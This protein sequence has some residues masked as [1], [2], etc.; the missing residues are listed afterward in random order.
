MKVLSTLLAAA[1]SLAP[2]AP[3]A[4]EPV[5]PLAGLDV[6][7]MIVPSEDD[8][9]AG[10]LVSGHVGLGHRWY[11][12]LVRT[13]Y[14]TDRVDDP[15]DPVSVRYHD[16]LVT[17]SVRAQRGRAWVDLGYGW[18]R[19]WWTSASGEARTSDAWRPQVVLGVDV[20]PRAP[21]SRG[22]LTV[23]LTLDR[24]FWLGFGVRR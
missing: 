24:G 8:S 14:A 17:P 11:A 6:G 4:A 16:L 15:F 13:S 22:A 3:S 23:G 10:P 21:A 2:I 5:R 18:V 12:A 20:G 19:E 1:C 7:V 9:F